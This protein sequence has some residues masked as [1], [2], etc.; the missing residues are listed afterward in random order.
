MD[1]DGNENSTSPSPQHPISTDS[2]AP[3]FPSTSTQASPIRSEQSHMGCVEDEKE[4]L[5]DEEVNKSQDSSMSSSPVPPLHHPSETTDSQATATVVQSVNPTRRE[6]E[7][8]QLLKLLSEVQQALSK[9]FEKFAQP[10]LKKLKLLLRLRVPIGENIINDISKDTLFQLD[11]DNYLTFFSYQAVVEG[12]RDENAPDNLSQLHRELLNLMV[13]LSKDRFLSN[14]AILSSLRMDERHGLTDN[15]LLEETFKTHNINF[16]EVP[17]N[18]PTPSTGT[19]KKSA[20]RETVFVHG[21]QRFDEIYDTDIEDVAHMK[22]QEMPRMS[23]ASQVLRNE[24]L[25]RAVTGDIILWSLIFKKNFA[26]QKSEKNMQIFVFQE[27]HHQIFPRHPHQQRLQMVVPA[28]SRPPQVILLPQLPTPKPLK[29]GHLQLMQ[30]ELQAE[31]NKEKSEKENELKKMKESHQKLLE[32]CTEM[33]KRLNEE[34]TARKAAKNPGNTAPVGIN[35]YLPAEMFSYGS[36]VQETQK[37][38]NALEPLGDELAALK[39]NIEDLEKE[40]GR[41]ANKIKEHQRTAGTFAN[42]IPDG[43]FL[44]LLSILQHRKRQASHEQGLKSLPTGWYSRL[45]NLTENEMER[46]NE[47]LEKFEKQV[48][49]ALRQRINIKAADSFQRI[50]TFFEQL[51][52]KALHRKMRHITADELQ[53]KLRQK[54][55]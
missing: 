55:L 2:P 49:G 11:H 6:L 44:S 48:M 15:D 5:T 50:F 26:Y 14:K 28:P 35:D 51:I 53:Q 39:K 32:K 25:F 30:F 21:A 29:D 3:N 43:K 42:S 22:Q 52:E 38:F 40:A 16:F 31:K 4:D 12:E 27:L 17:K 47:W 10:K 18:Q 20:K 46:L 24:I 1:R 13:S 36:L 54:D 34:A 37:K 23:F 7:E 19:P 8:K 41:S 45:N 9:N 33:D